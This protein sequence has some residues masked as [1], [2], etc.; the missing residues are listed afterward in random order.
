M[1]T[2]LNMNIYYTLAACYPV[3]LSLEPIKGN[4]LTYLLTYFVSITYYFLVAFCSDRVHCKKCTNI[5]LSTV[6]KRKYTW[7][8][9]IGPFLMKLVNDDAQKRPIYQIML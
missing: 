9:K 2:M 1:N 4:L 8:A 7:R 5:Y 6:K 3:R